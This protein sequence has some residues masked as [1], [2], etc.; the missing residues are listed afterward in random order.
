MRHGDK[1]DV[2]NLLGLGVL[3]THAFDANKN[4]ICRHQVFK[5]E[6]ES[7][8]KVKACAF[9]ADCEHRLEPV[10]A[11][12]RLALVGALGTYCLLTVSITS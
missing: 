11:G 12:H 1:L 2:R 4:A 8:V 3:S 6:H 9:Y 7:G 5:T 10:T